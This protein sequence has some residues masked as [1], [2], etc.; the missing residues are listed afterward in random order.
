VNLGIIADI[1]AD[2]RALAQAL[3]LLT[4]QG[5]DLIVCAGDLVEKGVDG[6]AV[7]QLLQAEQILSVQGNHDADIFSN[8][9]FLRE[10]GDPHNPNLRARLLMDSTLDYLR[11]L[12]TTLRL[13]L[14]DRLILVAHGT[15][16]N[17]NEYVFPPVPPKQWRSDLAHYS[18]A[19]RSTFL[20]MAVEGA[21]IVILGHTH[22]PM[23]IRAGGMLVLNAGSVC[24]PQ[25]GSHTC[26]LLP[27]PKGVFTVYD[28][29]TGLPVQIDEIGFNI[30]S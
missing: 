21:D 29:G 6:D 24:G 23:C 20:R 16:W 5:A 28:I 8:Q 14:E 9:V 2:V 4:H 17:R 11:V 30:E 1:H 3:D 7:I 26:G 12:P 13:T 25:W 18:A 22:L 15:P 27:L 10:H 19:Q